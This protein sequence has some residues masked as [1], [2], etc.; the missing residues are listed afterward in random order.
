VTIN[1][2]NAEVKKINAFTGFPFANASLALLKMDFE[3]KVPVI[4]RTKAEAIGNAALWQGYAARKGFGMTLSRN[5]SREI[6]PTMI[7]KK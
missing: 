1:T 7:R 5:H 6:N 3:N 4:Q 2:R